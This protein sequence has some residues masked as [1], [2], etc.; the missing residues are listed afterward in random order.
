MV[1]P[2]SRLLQLL[3]LIALVLAPICMMG[4]GAAM[5]ALPATDAAGHHAAASPAHCAEMDG[6]QEDEQERGGG[7]DC[8]MACAGVLAQMHAVTQTAMVAGEPQRLP[9][10]VEALGLNPAAEPRPPRLS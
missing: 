10:S 2:A 5:A 8:R 6:Q 1:M 9:I 4:G 7:V 3:L